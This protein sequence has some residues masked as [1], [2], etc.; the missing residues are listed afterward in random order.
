M[1]EDATEDAVTRHTGRWTQREHARFIEGVKLYGH[2][3]AKVAQHV[4]TRTAKQVCLHAASTKT[5]QLLASF[6]E[7]RDGVSLHE[8]PWTEQE[9]A[10]FTQAVQLY[11]RDRAKVAEHVGTRTAKQVDAHARESKTKE[12]LASAEEAR[13]DGVWV[14][15]GRWTRP[16]PGQGGEARRNPYRQAG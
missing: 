3:R 12:W 4:G 5:K 7:T 14:Q 10:L 6:E 2:N 1:A 9:H 16:Q 13:E 11:G 15:K 8:G